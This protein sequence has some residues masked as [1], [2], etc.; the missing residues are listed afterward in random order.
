[1]ETDLMAARRTNNR[2]LMDPYGDIYNV[3][4]TCF[5]GGLSDA[6]VMAAV[7]DA[8]STGSD[9]PEAPSSFS[10][11]IVRT[12]CHH[13]YREIPKSV[14]EPVVSITVGPHGD[15]LEARKDGK[16]WK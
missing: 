6:E 4:F 10:I 11:E 14:S 16:L 8:R 5:G 1:V 3:T 13:I 2:F 15:V 12:K 9:L 7:V